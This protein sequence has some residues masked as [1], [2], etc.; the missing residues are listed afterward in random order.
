[1][2]N[3]IFT[4][5]SD[6]SLTLPVFVGPVFN[7]PALTT[8]T[9]YFVTVRGAN[10]CENVVGNAKIVTAVV[11]PPAVM[12][13]IIISGADA[14]FCAGNTVILT[15]SSTTV[16]SPI[17]MWY[18]DAALT[19][20]VFTGPV[21]TI[22]SA[23]NSVTYYVTVRGSNKCENVADTARIVNVIVNPLPEVPTI[24]SNGT[25]ICSGDPT[26]LT[27]QN[28]QAGITYQWYNA[29]VGGTL[30]NTGTVFNTPSI[31]ASVD[32]YVMA[33][34]PAG[35]G[36]PTGRV[37]VT[38]TVTP[39]PATPTVAVPSIST[40]N[41]NAVVLSITNPIAGVTYRWYNAAVGGVLLGTGVDFVT[42]AITATTIF[43]AEA[44]NATC[45]SSSRTPVTVIPTTT[46]LAPASISGAGGPQ[47][48][49]T[50]TVLTVDNPDPSLTYRWYTLQ[51][52]GTLLFEGSPFN[53]PALAAT[54]TFYVESINKLT[55]CVSQ[56]RTA[57]T[58]TV[59]PKL[60]A[61]V[62]IVQSA[63][64][65]SVTFQWAPVTGATGYE[66][67]IDNGFTWIVP[68]NGPTAT[69]YT[70]VGLKPDQKVSIRVRAYGQLT[71]QLSD[72]T[73]K[74]GSAEN[75]QGNNVF[76]PNTF[77]PNGDGKNDVFYVYGNTVA[78]MKLRV[79]NQWGQ[80]LYESL[81][82]Q[83]GWDGTYRGELQPNGVY[84]Y[85]V[86]IEF[87]DGSKVTRK[88]TITLLR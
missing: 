23:A 20:A 29:A 80:F 63:T 82:I 37:K 28:A 39:K 84:V 85:Y 13:D 87:N 70:F 88:G 22:P 51:S 61:P 5:Y 55:G 46:P 74:D 45:K 58:V 77:T 59:L 49:G 8:T 53:V 68:T 66:V 86:D 76:I 33:V 65:S 72:A 35:C 32:Y 60:D 69:S 40:C 31:N 3:P 43:Y 11:N 1:V 18:T 2:V 42:P 26:V 24:S 7:T 81:T 56:S 16:T 19:N 21:L 14:P 15:A 4:W 75:P 83:N 57:V 71:C 36:N 47:C 54:T 38:V 79:Y 25:N 9:T 30:V 64:A 62:V 12:A 48:L 78:K 6:A 67:S 34:S 52:G 50:G 41:G 73:T 27:I 44:A 17:F 10:K